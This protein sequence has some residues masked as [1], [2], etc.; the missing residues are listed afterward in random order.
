M[1]LTLTENPLTESDG[2]DLISYTLQVDIEDSWNI[3]PIPY[4]KYSSSDGFRLGLKVFYNNA[5]G[6]LNDFYLGTNITFDYD[7]DNQSW[8]NTSWTI[9]PQ[10]NDVKIGGLEY[11]FGFMQQ[12]S[13]SERKESGE[14][15]E[16]YTYYNTEADVRTTRAL[17]T[18]K[19]IFLPGKSRNRDQLR[20]QRHRT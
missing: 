14:Y 9:N 17:R 7:S 12:N 18:G 19:Q 10:L 5:L 3:Y 6:S 15:L 8:E 20:L 13:Y 11:D 4:P 16:K 2:T 1:N